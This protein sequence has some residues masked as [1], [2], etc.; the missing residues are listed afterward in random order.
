MDLVVDKEHNIYVLSSGG[1][2]IK[3]DSTGKEIARFEMSLNFQSWLRLDDQDRVY[4]EYPDGSLPFVDSKLT[5]NPFIH[6]FEID[7]SKGDYS[8]PIKILPASSE[9]KQ[10]FK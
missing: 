5:G 8:V 10:M 1:P 6:S 9:N 7:W 4:M 3:F 2:I